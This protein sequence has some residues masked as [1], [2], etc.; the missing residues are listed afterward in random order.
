M[1]KIL[2]A[3][4]L[5]MLLPGCG[6]FKEAGAVDAVVVVVLVAIG[7]GQADAVYDNHCSEQFRA[8]TTR[9]QWKKTVAIYRE[10]L[11]EFKSCNHNSFHIKSISGK[12]TCQADYDVQWAKA[13]G[14]VEVDMAKENGV[15]KLTGLIV[16]SEALAG[17][18]GG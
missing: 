17:A 11:G 10:K 2:V 16:N 15:W 1:K 3:S 13:T 8:S 12:T 7:N 18:A 14:T 5:V 9:Q 6:M 4:L